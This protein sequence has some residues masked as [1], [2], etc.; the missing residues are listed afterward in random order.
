MQ[1]EAGFVAVVVLVLVLVAHEVYLA[2][3]L[4]RTR[5][6]LR[7]LE[8][9]VRMLDL[10]AKR[11]AADLERLA[12]VEQAQASASAPAATSAPAPAAALAVGVTEQDDDDACTKVWTGPPAALVEA[13][14]RGA[15][16]S[17]QVP[18]RAALSMDVAP[19]AVAS[20]PPVASAAQEATPRAFLSFDVAPR[21]PAALAPPLS[22]A[23]QLA[24][25]LERP[26]STRPPPHA[27]PVRVRTETLAGMASPLPRA[28]SEGD[29][30]EQRPSW[31][32]LKQHGGAASTRPP[33]GVA[34]VVAAPR[35]A[36][37]L[38]SM[39]AQTA[40]PHEAPMRRDAVA[41]TSPKPGDDD[42]ETTSALAFDPPRYGPRSVALRPPPLLAPLAD[43]SLI[44]PEDRADDDERPSLGP[45]EPTPPRGV[46]AA[47]LL[48]VVQ[49]P[50]EGV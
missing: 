34:P 38:L 45:D 49:A 29:A 8:R 3:S 16:P 4:A 39:Q 25:G 35:F 11:R 24:A 23:A 46:R 15:N 40:T 10:E 44:G 26:K 22:R 41:W 33:A 18:P 36:P 30:S 47:P 1:R 48:P 43:P 5:V 13:A 37:T 12:A 42:G 27:P 50:E 32:S 21:A 20:P 17:S 14:A 19:R 28:P 9:F 6:R 2:W 31:P 7:S